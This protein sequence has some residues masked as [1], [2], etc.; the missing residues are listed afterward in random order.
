MPR[1]QLGAGIAE[2]HESGGDAGSSTRRWAGE[3]AV[4]RSKG[5]ESRGLSMRQEWVLDLG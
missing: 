4:L 5:D 1:E 3:R 2:D